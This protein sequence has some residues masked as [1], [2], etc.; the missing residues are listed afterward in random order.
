MKISTLGSLCQAETKSRF[1]ANQFFRPRLEHLE[2]RRLLSVSSGPTPAVTAAAATSSLSGYAYV[3]ANQNHAKDPG[4]PGIPSVVVV[5]T[6][7]TSASTPVNLSTTTDSTGLYSFANLATGNYTITETQPTN[8]IEG[9]N[10]DQVGSQNSGTVAQTAT[11]N[12]IQNITLAAGVNGAGNNFGNVGE[13]MGSVSKRSFLDPSPI[14]TITKV[15]NVG[16]SSITN[17]TGNVSQGQ[18]I[19]YTVVVSNVGPS[20]ATDTTIADSTLSTDLASDTW[21]ATST[22]S[23]AATGFSASGTGNINDTNVTLPAGSSITYVITGTV[24]STVTGTLSNTASVTPLGSSS[25]TATDNDNLPTLSITKVDNAGGSSITP[26]TGNVTPG[27]SLTYT[28]VVSNSGPGSVN[29]ATITDPIPSD[30]TGDTWTAAST[31]SVAATGFATS[32]SGNIDQTGVNLPANSAITYT[33]TGTVTSTATGTFSNTATVAPPVGTPKTATDNDNLVNLSITKIDSAGGSSITPSTGS[34]TPGQS[35]TYTVVVSNSGPGSET[36][37]TITDPIPSDLTGVTWTA[38]ST[39]SVAATGFAT[40]GS[41]NIDQTGVN[42]P[43]NSAITYTITGTVSSTSTGTFSNTATVTSPVGTPKTATDKDNL[44]DLSITKVDNAGGS[45]ITPSTGNVLQGESL[46]YTVVVSNS[47]PGSVTG[48]TITDPIPSDLTGDTWTAASTGSVA[49]T[50]FATSGSGNINQTGVNLPANSAVTYTITGMVSSTATGTFSN[51]ATVAPPVGTPK[52]ATDSDN[53]PNLSITKTDNAGGSSITP[54]TGNVLQGQ[55]L[56]YIVVVSN[57]G[58]GNVTGATITDPI[59][60]DLTGDTW[61]AAST[62]SVAATGF[63]TSGSG[64]IDQTGVN[65]PANSA[66]T[67]TI[68]GTVSSTAT[69]TFSNTASVAPPIGSP[70]TATDSDNLPNLSIT[71]TDNAGGSSITP[72]TGNVTPGQSLTYSVVVSNTGPGGVT[73]ATIT[74]PIPSDLTGITWTAASTGSAAATGFATSGSGNI[75]QTGVNLPANSAITYTITGTVTSTATGTFSNTA[76]VAP[77]IGTP[78]T[79]TDSDNLADLSIAKVDNAG[80]SSITP[81]TGNVLQG[82]SLTYTVVVSNS[83]PGDV[84]GAT[85][86]DPIPSDLTGDTWTAASTGGVAATGFA[87]SGSGNINQTGVNLP[88]DSAITY[89]ITGTVSSTATGTFSNTA[90]VAPPSGTPKTATDTDNLPN[91]SITKVDN[92]GGS[93]ITPS[94]GNALQSQSLTY[95][96]VV[97]NSGPGS[98][99]GATITDPIPSD[100]TGDTWTALSTGSVAATGFATSGS[101]NIDQ[102]GVNLPANSAITYTI[103]GTVSSSA[104]GTFSNTAA[105]APPIGTAKTA[106]DSDNLPFLSIDKT[107]NA[108]GSSSTLSIGNVTNGQTLIYTITISNSGPGSVTGVSVSDPLPSE[109]TNANY[110]TT[111]SGGATDTTPSGTGVTTITD[112]VS[113]PAGS[114]IVYTVTGTLDIPTDTDVPINS[115]SNTVSE[116]PTGG[117]TQTATDFDNVI[118]LGISKTDNSVDSSVIPGQSLTYTVVVTNHGAGTATGVTIVDPVPANFT[119]DTWTAASTTVPAATG[120]S[121]TGSGNIDDTNVTMPPDSSI[122][123]T[124]TGTVSSTATSGSTLTNTATATPPGGTPVS[125]TDTDTVGTP[126]LSI[127]KVD[128]AGGSSITPATGNVIP[129]QSLTYTVVVSNTGTGAV[130]GATVSDPLPST[131]DSANY[132]TALTGGATDMNPSGT[133]VTSISDTVNLPGGSS[134][135]YTITGTVNSTAVGQLKNAATITPAVGSPI[136]ATDTDNLTGLEIEKSDDAGGDSGLQTLTSSPAGTTGSTAVDNSL[137]YTV[138]VSNSGPGFLNGATISDVFPAGYAETSWASVESGGAT[139]ATSNSTAG[140]NIDDTVDLPSGSS[141]TYTISGTVVSSPTLSNTATV[142]PSVGTAVS[143]T[144]ND[145]VQPAQIAVVPVFGITT[146]TPA[147]AASSTSTAPTAGGSTT[148]NAAAVDAALAGGAGPHEREHVPQVAVH[149]HYP[150]TLTDTALLSLDETLMGP[151]EWKL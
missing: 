93:S 88:A 91:L 83:G 115:I 71:K 7:T 137:T 8:F 24:S 36:G 145:N 25:E 121:A 102:T 70:K 20:P 130:A 103:T 138:T 13:T 64:N 119:G 32:G 144:D 139:G 90:T 133:G 94:T 151:F 105:V 65:L 27:Q 107:D 135:T 118:R 37:A 81:S 132:T 9:V 150:A 96:V 112:T 116:T 28:V 52:T 44:A 29:G 22:G 49:A 18:S 5:L 123:Y 10:D 74:D 113:L 128:N 15:D 146:V 129:G 46:T 98:V 97:S 66:I 53:L 85:I 12:A 11:T 147:V 67:Y 75:D 125:A 35:L 77:P 100:L 101:G 87:T 86:T 1:S 30:L 54:S 124:V 80:G 131:F 58:P 78:K 73:G 21:T 134:I 106:T 61:T 23:P 69:G 84:T 122:T 39:G 109:L 117:I 110:T 40:S 142:T 114:S 92:R 59:P 60:S 50:G 26:S 79:A 42:L 148:L 82:Q 31:G 149:Y 63:A 72:S 95:T 4:E 14:L 111:L 6:G 76:S 17:T 141:I 136:S 43:A 62:G 41:G 126:D 47:G 3:D 45:S 108:G 48:A 55:S 57:S 99:T 140:T 89:V 120:F 38:T 33:I 16:G 56:T 19:T 127:T 68:T 143:A 34:V 51:T 2:D 104:S